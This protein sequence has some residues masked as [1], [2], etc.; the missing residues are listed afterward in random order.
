MTE[1]TPPPAVT[2]T[3]ATYAATLRFENIPQSVRNHVRLTTLDALGC[4]IQGQSLPWTGMLSETVIADGGRPETS[5]IGRREKVPLA[6]AA[7]VNATAGHAFE[8]D[9]IHRDAILHPNS[10]TVPVALN[11]AERRAGAPG[12]DMITAIVAAYEVANRIGAAAGTD[13]LLR[14]FHPQ[15]TIGAIAAAVTAARMMHLGAEQTL[16]AIGIAGSLGAGLMA[17]QEGAMV[18]R[19]HSGRAAEAGIRAADLAARGFTGIE[20][21]VEVSY[22]GFL[23]SFAGN[24]RWQRALDGLGEVWETERTGFKPHA[25][26]TSIHSSLDCLKAIMTENRLQ[27]TDITRIHAG[28]SKPTYV[29]CAWPYRAQSVTAAQMNIYYGLAM[30]ALEG[31][32]FVGQFKPERIAAP[33]TLAFIERIT[34]D[35]ADD[36]ET[37]GPGFRHM[38]RITVTTQDGRTFTKEEAHRRGSPENPVSAS[39]LEAKFDALTA[40]ILSERAASELKAQIDSLETSPD[41]TALLSTI[42]GGL[43]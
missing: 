7:L 37:R 16:Q 6:A 5:L 38:S 14:G 28:L 26:V 24:D 4:V 25:T 10:I 11:V 18:K 22:G 17:A 1:Q 32:A 3:L 39:N 40:A 2:R 43:A 20:D 35:V 30:I 33:E 27:A 15:G 36:I 9:D 23:S 21:L 42:T 12:R 13:L 19:L 41:V 34:A 8:L 29:H 31:A